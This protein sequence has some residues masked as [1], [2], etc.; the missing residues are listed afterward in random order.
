MSSNYTIIDL[1]G[2]IICPRP[3]KINISFLK[4]FRKLILKHLKK[5]EKFIIITGG[6][7][8][9]R[10]Y[11][12]AASKIV[13]L[14]SCPKTKYEGRITKE[15]LDWIGIHSTRLNAHL[16]RTIFFKNAY[17]VIIDNPKKTIKNNPSLII[18]SGWQPGW[19]TDYMAVLLAKRFKA[20]SLIVAS[21]ISHVYNKDYLKYRNAKKIKEIRWKDYRKLIPK[22]W[23]PGI[24]TPVDPVAT[25]EAQKIG[26]RTIVL[27]GTDLK[28][29]ENCLNNKQFKGTVIN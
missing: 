3:G 16:L 25:K 10:N 22:K 7:K 15:D 18:A 17:P 19:S 29:L 12:Q 1:G 28:N 13:S 21:A 26:L 11:Q 9:S 2:S 6:G 20:K 8:L 23:T 24:G 5:G 27:K 4:K 14:V